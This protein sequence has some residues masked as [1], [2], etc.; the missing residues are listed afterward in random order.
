MNVDYVFDY[1]F[2]CISSSKEKDIDFVMK[3]TK[4]MSSIMIFICVFEGHRFY[5]DRRLCLRFIIIIYYYYYYYNPF[6]DPQQNN[7]YQLKNKNTITNSNIKIEC[8]YKEV[9]TMRSN[10]S[11]V[12]SVPVKKFTID[13]LN[14]IKNLTS[15]TYNVRT[16]K[17]GNVSLMS[18]VVVV[19][20]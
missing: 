16:L 12:V 11:I 3:R 19:P 14:L 10:Q 9:E 20:N 4:I 2:I 13:K 18:Y 1:D 15:S 17:S 8:I 5:H 6:N 7:K